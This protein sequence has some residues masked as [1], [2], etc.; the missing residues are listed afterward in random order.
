MSEDRD[1]LELVSSSSLNRTGEG[2]GPADIENSFHLFGPGKRS[3]AMDQLD[4]AV[5]C[6][7]QALRLR[8]NYNTVQFAQ[9]K[10]KP[11]AMMGLHRPGS[12]LLT[13][14]EVFVRSDD[15]CDGNFVRY[16][17][18]ESRRK[19]IQARWVGRAA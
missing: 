4:Q 17:V 13:S 16:A 14:G 12:T 1:F 19:T 18:L 5:G 9:L 15:A 6:Y 11:P 8:P 7:Q 3:E 10:N 2:R